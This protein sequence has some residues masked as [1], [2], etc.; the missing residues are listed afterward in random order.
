MPDI[1]CLG[2]PVIDMVSTQPG[3]SLVEVT[4]FEKAAGG[5]PLNVA[6]GCALLGADVG[7]ICKLGDDGL[8]QF[9]R[10]TMDACGVDTSQMLSDPDHATQIAFVGVD[11]HGVPTFEF[12]IRQPAHEIL[13]PGDLDADYI[14]SAEIY[15]FGAIT[16]AREP[17][18]SA[19]YAALQI[20]A[21]NGALIS[22]DPNYRPTMWPDED[23]AIRVALE[24]VEQCDFVKVS[25]AELE[26]LGGTDDLLRGCANLYSMGPELIAVTLGAEGCFFYHEAG[27]AHLPGFAVPVDETTG[28]GDAFVAGV[29]VG[30]LESDNDIAGL[31]YDELVDIF[32]YANAAAAITATGKGAIPSLPGREEVDEMLQ[33][34]G[35]RPEDTTD[36]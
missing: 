34:T 13:S 32:T 3:I 16:L 23:S 25:K 36:L 30:L 5:A 29:L 20:A 10:L 21:D 24:A 28:C 2:E 4:S 11:P 22:L 18:R 31:G 7:V 17:M 35:L 1:I 19:T 26:L 33:R 14:A 9:M 27:S 6:A 8:G 12:H 15:H